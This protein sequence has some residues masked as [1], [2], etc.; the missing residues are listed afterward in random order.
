MLLSTRLK[1]SGWI[2]LIAFENKTLA[3]MPRFFFYMIK[4]NIAKFD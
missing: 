1:I 4:G 3:V 2:N